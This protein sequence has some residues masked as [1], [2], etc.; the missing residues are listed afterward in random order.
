MKLSHLLLAGILFS[1]AAQAENCHSK[2]F[3]AKQSCNSERGHSFNSCHN[4]PLACKSK[5]NSSGKKEALASLPKIDIVFSPAFD[6]DLKT[7]GG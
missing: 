1:S 3:E 7:L 5:C 2:C 4:T 6:A